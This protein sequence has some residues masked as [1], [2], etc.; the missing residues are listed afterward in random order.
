MALVVS[1]LHF[2]LADKVKLV[3]VGI[4]GPSITEHGPTV[5]IVGFIGIYRVVGKRM[6][7]ND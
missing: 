7:G 2:H 3:G 5:N 1:T 4:D 6:G